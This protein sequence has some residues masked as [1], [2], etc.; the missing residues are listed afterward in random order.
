[1]GP[2]SPQDKVEDCPMV[3]IVDEAVKLLITGAGG[4]TVTATVLVVV[5]PELLAVR[6]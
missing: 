1:M 3:I 2:E 4:L 5:P 6:V